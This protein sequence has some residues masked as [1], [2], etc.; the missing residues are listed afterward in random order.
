MAGIVTTLA[1]AKFYVCATA[2]TPPLTKS[3]FEALTWV[4]V[5]HVGKIGQSGTDTNIVSYDTLGTD[6]TQKG[7]GIADGGNMEIEVARVYDDAGQVALRAAGLTNQNYAT[8]LELADS[9]NGVLS[10]T[11][12]Y[13]CGIVVGP[14]RPNGSNED[15]VVEV[16]TI[17]NNQVEVVANPA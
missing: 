12:M 6:V 15:F 14:K 2:Q 13:N 5:G 11:I 9:P 1:D 17:G 4:Q 10:N 3:Q 7:K 16:F 8:K